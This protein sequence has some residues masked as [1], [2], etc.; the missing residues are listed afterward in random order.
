MKKN[1]LSLLLVCLMAAMLLTQ[2]AFAEEKWDKETELLVMGCGPAGISAA[3][4]AADN[5]CENVIIIE[6]I[7]PIGGT[8][9]ISE[10]ILS[11]YETHLAGIDAHYGGKMR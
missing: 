5:G 11:G 6:K 4:E 2:S 8:A 1:F 7:G 3:V 9:L 10:G